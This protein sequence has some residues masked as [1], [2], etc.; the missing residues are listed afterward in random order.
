VDSNAMIFSL[1]F[2]NR[3]YGYLNI[4]VLDKIK[5]SGDEFDLLLDVANDVAYALHKYELEAQAKKE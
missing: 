5:E 1:K 4:S 3:R 2:Q